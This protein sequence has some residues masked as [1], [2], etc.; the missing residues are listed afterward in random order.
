[1]RIVH[2]PCDCTIRIFP[3]F[4]NVLYNARSLLTCD[5][6]RWQM[7]PRPGPGGGTLKTRTSDVPGA[8]ETYAGDRKMT[9]MS[10]DTISRREHTSRASM[11]G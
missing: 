7:D 3:S 2:L 10:P 11:R 8:T 1:M 4:I 5:M 6:A 9:S